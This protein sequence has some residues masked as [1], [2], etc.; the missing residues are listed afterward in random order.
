[1]TTG[2]D[3]LLAVLHGVVDPELGIDIVDL[4]LV[5]GLRRHEGKVE[6]DL[7]MTTPMCPYT[8]V[9]ADEARRALESVPGVEE[10]TVTVTFD[11]PWS[12]EMMSPQARAALGW[13]R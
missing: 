4:G 7:G 8:G 1:M 11:P 13:A 3:D 6:L 5:Y 9:L 10:A 12:P 2:A